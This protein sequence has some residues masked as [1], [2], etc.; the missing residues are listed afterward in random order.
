MLIAELFDIIT[1]QVKDF[2]LKHD[3]VRVIQTAIKYAN[4]TQ[5]KMIATELK[6]EY[7]G[8]SESR[9]AKFLIGKL[10]VHGDKEVRD[11][12][13]PEF[14]GH[15]RRLIKH[16]EAS[17]ILDDIYRGVATPTQKA[18]LLR[19]WYGA[20]FAIFRSEGNG[21][22][23]PD[24]ERILA[25]HP[26]KRKPIMHALHDLINLLVQKQTTGFT[27]LH[28]A[29]LQ[30]F[31]NV[32]PNGE[33][34]TEF[35]E[36]LK[37]D[38]EGDLLKNLAFTKS[39]SR[40]VC[41]AFAY[42]N[43]KDRK[44]LLR[45]YKNTFHSMAFDANGH[46][47]I[48]AALEVI[49]DTVLTS[50]SIFS[51]LV[52]KSSV[53]NENQLRT[54]L[55]AVID[56]KARIPI[57][58]P[59]AGKSKAILPSE[60][61]DLLDKIHAIRTTTSKKDPEVRRKELLAYLSPPLLS[62]IAAETEAL[63]QSSFGCQCI[64]EVLLSAPGDRSSALAALVAL[65]NGS[66][67]EVE[68]ALKTPAAGRMLKALV[69]GGRFNPITK[70]IDLTEPPLGLHDLLFKSLEKQ[71]KLVG[72]ATGG[73][74]FVVLAMLE[75]KDF[76]HKKELRRI[77]KEQEEKLIAATADD[78]SVVEKGN[79]KK[80]KGDQGRSTG[81]RGSQLLLEKLAEGE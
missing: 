68:E 52:S 35:I 66:S 18:I 25:Q 60:D 17:W 27:M 54:L 78:K 55:T 36:L 76:G 43:A 45:T 4:L 12:I 20:E 51:E 38:E 61:L 40:V 48:L 49:D 21:A 29:M 19:E 79:G 71:E 32:T 34:A 72:W 28:D 74:S 47:V 2:V 62:L 77:L 53:L 65:T 5:R 44:L 69:Q 14:Y 75:S 22:M 9:Y 41:L 57:L 13:V 30:Y 80:R 26:E 10:L 46:Q 16:P 67:Q 50:K 59:F 24:L 73:N 39:G 1:G 64:T 58:Y 7:R 33:E 31:Q 11:M 8:L 70:A 56:L 37:G 63:V 3:S 15:V 6:G 42:S 23:D 81:N